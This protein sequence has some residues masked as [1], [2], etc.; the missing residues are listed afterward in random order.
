MQMIRNDGSFIECTTECPECG[1]D[2]IFKYYKNGPHIDAYCAFCNI[3]VA[4]CK[5]KKNM[6]PEWARQIK[7]RDQYTCQRCGARLN[8]NRAKAHHILP[9]WFMPEREFDLNNGICLCPE[10]HKQIHGYGGTIKDYHKGEE[11]YA[12]TE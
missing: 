7:E 8:G 11:D 3:H 5:T 9:V 4:Y 6:R 10:C 12:E 1:N 2:S